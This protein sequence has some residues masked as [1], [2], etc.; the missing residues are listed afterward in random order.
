MCKGTQTDSYNVQL[1][2]YQLMIQCMLM[3]YMSRQWDGNPLG[4]GLVAEAK[5][6]EFS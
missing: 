1:H 6:S 5:P 4:L 3:Y 2:Y